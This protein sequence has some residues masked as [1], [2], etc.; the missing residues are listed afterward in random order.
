V[1]AKERTP[2][3]PSIPSTAEQGLTGVETYFWAGIF[4]PAHTPDAIVQKLNE[5]TSQALDTPATAQ[6]LTQSGA[7]VMPKERRSVAYAKKFV[8]DEIADWAKTIK[9]SNISLD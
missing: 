7:S 1:L 3:F 6:R 9:A 5:V 4:Y 8:N 2:L